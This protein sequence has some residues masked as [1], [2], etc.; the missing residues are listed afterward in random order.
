[1]G[2]YWHIGSN[3]LINILF[4]HYLAK[5]H[6]AERT[7]QQNLAQFRSEMVQDH[8]VKYSLDFEK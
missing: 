8:F 5:N 7:L 2:I 3:E 4:L 1:M 6:L